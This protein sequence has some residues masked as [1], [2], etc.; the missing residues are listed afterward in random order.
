MT[1]LETGQPTL[2]D[3]RKYADVRMLVAE[4]VMLPLEI[5]PDPGGGL[6][7]AYTTSTAKQDGN[8]GYVYVKAIGEQET[9]TGG[10]EAP[11]KAKRA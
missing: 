3:A 8:V 6:A 1:H 9:A 2:G 7:L 4:N 5:Q 11:L 10:N